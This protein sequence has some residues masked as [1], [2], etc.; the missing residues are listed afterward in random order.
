MINGLDLNY[1]NKYKNMFISFSGGRTSSYMTK[2]LIEN[3]KDTHNI[4]VLFA[5]TGQ[6][7]EETLKFIKKCDDEWNFNTI[8]LE[9]VVY[10]DKKKSNGWKVV[11]FETATRDGSLFVEDCKKYG[12]MNQA[13]PHCT[14][15][16]KTYPMHNY[17]KDNGWKHGD[18]ITAVG[19]RADE[20]DRINMNYR[21]RHYWY[22]LAD[23][24][25]TKEDIL[26]FFKGNDFDLNIPEYLGNCV[27]C[28]KKTLRKHMT[29]IDEYPEIYEV[30][31]ML[32]NKFKSFTRNGKLF[33]GE[34]LFRG[35]KSVEDL[36]ALHKEGNFDLWVDEYFNDCAESCEAMGTEKSEAM[37]DEVIKDVYGK[38]LSIL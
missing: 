20:V 34:V 24:G 18:Y 5:N 23:V 9:A 32:E 8:W 35:K 36:F 25:V 31:R 38:Q 14:R 16:L 29:L 19:I 1:V 2:W 7:H 6:E 4:K 30:P 15:D 21:K 17:I 11:N 13:F 12:L 27:W 26:G 10:H 37:E 33:E 22:P 3:F 28:W